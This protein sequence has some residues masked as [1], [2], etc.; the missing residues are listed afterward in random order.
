MTSAAA[1][2]V[3]LLQ[4]PTISTSSGPKASTIALKPSET[5]R[6][7]SAPQSPL[8]RIAPRIPSRPIKLGNPVAGES[9][10]SNPTVPTLKSASTLCQAPS[11]SGTDVRRSVSIAAFPQPPQPPKVLSRKVTSPRP[12]PSATWPTL[13]NSLRDS[14]DPGVRGILGGESLK[15]RRLKTKNSSIALS[16]MYSSSHSPTMLNGT[17][18]GKTVVSPSG[19]RISDGLNSLHSPAHSRSSSAQGSYSTSATT[20]EDNEDVVR[21]GRD[22]TEP[23]T[24]VGESISAKESKGN[25]IV[26]VRVRPDA[27]DSGDARA[28][29]EWLVDGRRSLIS[30]RGREGGDYYYGSPLASLQTSVALTIL[31]RQCVRNTR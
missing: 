18:D 1:Q 5:S 4:P 7:P 19:N 29:G 22:A 16:T 2:P 17:G 27:A 15:V 9:H 30:Y 6:I 10:K 26:S 25:V 20:F 21:K 31:Y 13:K 8:G 28:E 24:N 11:L 3:S 23:D 14:E 12:S